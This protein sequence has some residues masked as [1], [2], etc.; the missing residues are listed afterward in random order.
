MKL[1]LGMIWDFDVRA[2]KEGR[3]IMLF[4]FSCSFMSGWEVKVS[5]TIYIILCI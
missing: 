1:A 4:S 5:S 2:S 3:E